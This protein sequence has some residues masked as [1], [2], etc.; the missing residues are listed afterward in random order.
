MKKDVIKNIAIIFLAVLLVL[1]FFSN[2]IMNYSLPQVSA[3]YASQ[4]TIS[5]QIRGSGSV[6]PA[7]SYEV[8]FDQAREIKSVSVKAGQ[9]VNAGDVLFELADSESTELKEAQKTLD[10]LE[11]D[12]KKA[13]LDLSSNSLYQ[14]DYL[15]IAKAEEEL[16]RL[17]KLLASSDSKTDV[18]SVAEAEYIA[19]KEL[20]DELTNQKESYNT[21]LA[22]A[23]PDGDMLSLDKVY[24]DRLSAASEAVK[25]AQTDL[26]TAQQKYDKYSKDVSSESAI[27]EQISAKQREIK[28]AEADLNSAYAKYAVAETPEDISAAYEEVQRC[29][30]N[31][32]NLRSELSDIYQSQIHNNAAV[33]KLNNA[34]KLLEKAQKALNSAKEKL[35]DEVRKVKLE[36]RDKLNDTEEKL[37]EAQL[38][39]AAAEKTKADAEAAGFMSAAQLSIKITQQEQKIESLR[40]DL[41]LKQSADQV[42]AD[43]S[44]LD[45]EAKLK[46]VEE[47]R[48]KVEK[49]KKESF[50]AVVTAKIAGTVESVYAAAGST[51]EAGSVAA[52]INVSDLGYSVQFP[53]K[54]EQA[55]KVKVGDKAEITSWYWGDDFS[56]T[57]SEILPDTQNPQTQKLLVFRVQGS[58]ITTG[59]TISLSMGSKG[60]NYSVVIP[61]NAVRED[62][63][64][65]FVLVMESKSSPLGNRYKAVRYDIEVLAKDD[66]HT[67]VNGLTGSEFVITTSTKPISAGEQVRPAD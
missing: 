1:T 48:S 67:A 40:S 31:L 38:R 60:Q 58:D 44:Q 21:Q 28:T 36:I 2:T 16:E 33:S 41:A 56:A 64:G 4:G 24:Y 42:T 61:N 13:L 51:V 25:T 65:K 46:E 7:E 29:Q 53:V 9:K 62:S 27:Q 59:Q 14:A 3:T 52:V 34:E 47:Q 39:L 45:L 37:N 26:D 66:N 12:Y 49:L 23:N 43:K 8:K 22:D 5:E 19:A 30:L 18:Y 17:K 63:N 6:E 55:R 57:L 50:D 35:A 20:V 54:A 10:T 11:L 15:E 32:E